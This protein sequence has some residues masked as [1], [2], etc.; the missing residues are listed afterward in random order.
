MAKFR[1]FLSIKQLAKNT[2][3]RINSYFYDRTVKNP[4]TVQS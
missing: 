1:I 3:Y 2:I 4:T